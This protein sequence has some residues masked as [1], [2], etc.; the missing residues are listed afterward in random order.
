MAGWLAGSINRCLIHKLKLATH[1]CQKSGGS[2]ERLNEMIAGEFSTDVVINV[3]LRS[4]RR[5]FFGKKKFSRFRCEKTIID[6]KG[7]GRRRKKTEIESWERKGYFH[8]HGNI[9]STV[10]N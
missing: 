4:F 10:F 9:H 6:C 5:H 8:K 1:R 2:S 3:P 7:H